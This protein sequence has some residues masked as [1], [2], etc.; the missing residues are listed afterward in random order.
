MAKGPKIIIKNLDVKLGWCLRRAAKEIGEKIHEEYDKAIKHFYDSYERKTDRYGRYW[1]ERTYSLYKG[2]FGVGGR[3]VFM[4]KSSRYGYDCGLEVG[5]E[6]Y[7]GNPYEKNPP[8]GKEMTPEIVFPDA[9]NLGRHGF[10]SYTV[11]KVHKNQSKN[12]GWWK[13]TKKSVPQNTTPPIKLFNAS[14]KQINNGDYIFD[15]L[16][17]ALDEA[18]AFIDI[19]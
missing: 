4:K 11:G 3:N 2:A 7:D 6:F 14:F 8:H 16:Y 15:K 10:S 12:N 18:G 1:Y 13:I 9:F 19:E 17:K 5:H